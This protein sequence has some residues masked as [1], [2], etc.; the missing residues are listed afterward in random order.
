MTSAKYNLEPVEV[1][2]VKTKYRVIQTKLPVPQS[3]EIFRKLEN[4]EPRS[5]MGQ[6]PVVWDQ[7]EGFLVRDRW[8]NCWIDWSSGVLITNTG[9][10]RPEIIQALRETMD[11]PLLTSYVFVHEMRA[12]LADA[13]RLISPDPEQYRVFLLTTGSEA[14][15]NSIKLAKTYALE[16]Y[17]KEKRCI[18]SFHNAF[19]GRTMGAQ[20]A[21]GQ[22]AGKKWIVGEGQTFFQVPFPDG[23]KNEDTSF[24]LFLSA[25]KKQNVEPRQI[26]ALIT[27][28]YQG[29]GPD[30]LPYDYAQSL[31]E[32]CRKHDIV[33]IFDEV[34]AGFG[35]TGRMF[36]FEHY[37]VVPDMIVCGKGISS[38]LPLSAVIG[39]TDIMNLYPP[40]SM[41]STHSANP[42]SVT[43]AIASLK[44]IQE[45]KLVER[46]RTMGNMLLPGLQ[47]IQQKYSSV[48]G[49]VTGKGLV[50]GIQV[51]TGKDKK[52]DAETALRINERCFQKGLL[53]FA[54][55]GIA[56]ECIKIAP[57]LIIEEDALR[58]GIAVL[59]QACEEVLG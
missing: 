10:G 56:G 57:P 44:I 36:T 26:A 32:Y 37:D 33:M 3:L 14:I 50:A 48:L 29:V 21:G 15:E 59:E 2:A 40:G 4:S 11:R 54:P 13:L 47:R 25:L 1:P 7:A 5:M 27:E 12:E 51:V 20:L 42:L 6:P 22:P 55:V 38:S 34:Q 46:S 24:D 45:E 18:V 52:P 53:M 35:R 39:R 16:K 28:S 49:C 31:Q 9:H 8:G 19:H 17:G 41:T 30:F 58:E 23:F 43:A